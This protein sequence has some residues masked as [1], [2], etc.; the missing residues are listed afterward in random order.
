MKSE[1][2]A[3]IA[4]RR[5]EIAALMR[6]VLAKLRPRLPGATELVYDKKNSLVVGFCPGDRASEVITS[7]A[8]YSKWL[9]L[10]FFE[11]S[12]LPDPQ[13]LLQ[14]SG[15]IVRFI[16]I[17]SPG[18]IDRPAVKALIA[19][20]IKLADPPLRKSAKRRVIIRQ[21]L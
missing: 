2:D 9:N 17:T 16:R 18:D 10:Y 7:V 5:P 6:G 14:G 11:G 15:T 8:S 1:L 13:G 12:A 20:A 3:I 4:K 21:S 19:A